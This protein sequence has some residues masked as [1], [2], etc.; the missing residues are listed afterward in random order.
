MSRSSITDRL[1]KVL[2]LV[3]LSF[4]IFFVFLPIVTTFLIAFDSRAYLAYLP[5]PSLSLRWFESFL[6]NPLFMRSLSISLLIGGVAT[7][8][9]TIAGILTSYAM[10]RYDFSG[11]DA[12]NSLFLSPLVVPGVVTGFS[13]LGFFSFLG[14]HTSF[15]K[16]LIGHIIIT[17]PYTIRT[18]SATM[19]GFDITLEEA[20]MNLGA[21]QIRTFLNVTLHSIKPGIIAGAVFAFAMSLDDVAVSVF[22][23]DAYTSN[24][25]VTLFAY[26]K[27]QFDP[28]V[29]AASVLLMGFTFGIIVVIEKVM[30]IDQFVGIG[31]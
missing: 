31:T 25:P 8:V 22:L 23:V 1:G 11:K 19:L 3:A 29:A 14:Y 26:M 28:T 5:P 16:L 9:S 24:L 4:T 27:A 30:G 18:I 12:L 15:A 7:F 21:N 6:A 17:L 2:V 20:S 13:L 10:V